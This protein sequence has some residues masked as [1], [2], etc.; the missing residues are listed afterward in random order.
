MSDITSEDVQTWV[1][2]KADDGD[3]K[4]LQQVINMKLQM[5]FRVG[6]RVWFDGKTRGIIRGTITKM[7]AKSAK[8]VTD[9][10]TMW[11]VSPT[12]LNK[13]TLTKVVSP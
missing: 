12:F 6:D 1:M 4:L 5:Q 11:T 8:V 13:E 9:V 7:N 3:L 2:T 10:G